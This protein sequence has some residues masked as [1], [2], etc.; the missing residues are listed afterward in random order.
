MFLLKYISINLSTT[1]PK[2]FAN[3]ENTGFWKL[4]L[5]IIISFMHTVQPLAKCVNI[6]RKINLLLLSSWLHWIKPT[7]IT[8]CLFV[9]NLSQFGEHM[10]HYWLLRSPFHPPKAVKIHLF[11][12]IT[13]IHQ[14][15]IERLV[16]YSLFLLSLEFRSLSLLCLAS[17]TH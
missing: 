1:A 8:R 14:N 16:I 5:I 12:I 4:Q 7:F 3:R 2:T 13:C 9:I 17:G 15:S 11:L 6:I 10:N